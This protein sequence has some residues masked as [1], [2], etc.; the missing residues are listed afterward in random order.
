MLI[1]SFKAYHKYDSCCGVEV[2]VNRNNTVTVILTELPDNP[3]IIVDYLI[4]HLAT[5]IYK[6]YLMDLPVESIIWLKHKPGRPEGDE[7]PP[8]ESYVQALLVW[9]GE[10]FN[11]PRW[12]L[13]P[14]SDWHLY[15]LP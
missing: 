13:L 5:L 9:N 14:R 12:V 7:R 2:R 1:L 4:E 11:S 6:E 3:G 15:G 8:E 10:T